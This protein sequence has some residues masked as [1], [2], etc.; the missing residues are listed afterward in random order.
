[1]SM[2][3]L[4]ILL[5]VFAISG[6]STPKNVA[7]E[8]TSGPACPNA[9]DENK[10][11]YIGYIENLRMCGMEAQAR[12]L[13]KEE[14]EKGDLKASDIYLSML[15]TQGDLESGLLIAV[16]GAEKG[17]IFLA[18]WVLII[19]DKYN[20]YS[21]DS[22]IEKVHI[23]SFR[24][25]KNCKFSKFFRFMDFAQRRMKN[26]DYGLASSALVLAGFCERDNMSPS[27]K[28]NVDIAVEALLG[29]AKE[30]NIVD[31]IQAGAEKKLREQ[32]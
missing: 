28:K 15:E 22:L 29:K 32:R 17:D 13:A 30:L 16:K 6:C 26:T 7:I 5:V 14:A 19:S 1:M 8:V 12:N 9:F 11:S 18:E 23:T 24:T 10:S 27:Q 4:V 31:L 21:L 2:R 25:S 20:I 3:A